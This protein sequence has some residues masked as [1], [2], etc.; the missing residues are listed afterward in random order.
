MAAIG[1]LHLNWARGSSWP[2][3]SREELGELVAGSSTMP[4]T[5]PTVI[6]GAGIVGAGAVVVGAGGTSRLATIARLGVG[7]GL[8]G[9]AAVG[10]VAAARMLGLGE[11]GAR[12]RRLDR[13]LY[14][15]LC[16]TLGVMVLFAALSRR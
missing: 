12:F 13:S 16:A 5:V 14:R 15:P 1:A 6:V 4:P 7:G 11:P 2:A 8:L 3:G 10:G 9:R